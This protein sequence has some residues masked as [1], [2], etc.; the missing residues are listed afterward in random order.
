MR[1]NPNQ[2]PFD[3]SIPAVKSLTVRDI[4]RALN[5]S[6]GKIFAAIESG[7]LAAVAINRDDADRMEWRVPLH[8]YIAWLNCEYTDELLYRFPAHEWLT[9]NRI[10][11][12]LN[13]CDQHIHNLIDSRE[14][15][16]AENLGL[17]GKQKRWRVPLRDLVDFINRR[18]AGGSVC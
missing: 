7:R 15:P 14:F 12:F 6:P 5:V 2:L 13:C 18:K 11:R 17:P 1:N 4:S 16:N 10:A 8:N 9:V 3:F